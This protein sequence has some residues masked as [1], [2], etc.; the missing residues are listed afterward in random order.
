M[1]FI[2]YSVLIIQIT[3]LFKYAIQEKIGLAIQISGYLV[4]R[5]GCITVAMTTVTSIKRTSTNRQIFSRI[6]AKI[7]GSSK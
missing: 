5:W 6:I 3:A 4:G 7:F 1:G 2:F